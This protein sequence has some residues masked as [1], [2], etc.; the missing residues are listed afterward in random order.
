VQKLL[1]LVAR[2]NRGVLTDVLGDSSSKDFHL[3]VVG[4]SAHLLYI[5]L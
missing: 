4:G 3:I 1:S 2:P 5:G